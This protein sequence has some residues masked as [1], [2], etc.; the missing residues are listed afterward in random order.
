GSDEALWKDKPS[1]ERWAALRR[2]TDLAQF[3]ARIA[4]IKF[5]VAELGRRQAAGDAQA[6]RLNFDRLGMSGH[7]SGATATLYLGGQR[8]A[9]AVAERLVGDLSEARFAAFL[10]FSPQAIGADPVQQ[11]V[12]FTRPALLVTGTLDG[13]PIPGM[14]ASPE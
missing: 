4:D 7:S 12:G 8:P 14:G 11:F 9:T 2:G 10:A 13:R 1:G 3:L 5:V 6:T